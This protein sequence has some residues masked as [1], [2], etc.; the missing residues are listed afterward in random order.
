MSAKLQIGGD[1][2]T[3]IKALA[4]P[5]SLLVAM[6]GVKFLKNKKAQKPDPKNGKSSNKKGQTKGK[7]QQKGGCG[8]PG[9]KLTTGGRKM[10]GGTTVNRELAK[11][12][13]DIRSILSRY[14]S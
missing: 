8:C 11:L 1:L 9:N 14:T 3:D 4:I 10:I 6:N 13:D 7:P 12:S 2:V 5:F